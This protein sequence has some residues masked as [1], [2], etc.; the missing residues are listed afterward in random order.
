MKQNQS[1]LFNN[2]LSGSGVMTATCFRVCS[3]AFLLVRASPK[4]TLMTIFKSLG[5][6]KVF[7]IP[8]SSFNLAMP[9]F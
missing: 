6:A 8:S 1:K 7:L 2:K 5:K 9:S 3:M 4:L